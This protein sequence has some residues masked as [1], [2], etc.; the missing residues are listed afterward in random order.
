[1]GELPLIGFLVGA[2]VAG[3]IVF[4]ESTF[5]TKKMAAGIPR[6][7][8]DRMP[9][10]MIGGILFP[11]TMFWFAWSA[12]YNSVPWI[13]PTLVSWADFSFLFFLCTFVPCATC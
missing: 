13:V 8:E 7:P 2:F 6:A 5:A 10:A 3:G 11:V 9:L 1:M 12:N 4:Y